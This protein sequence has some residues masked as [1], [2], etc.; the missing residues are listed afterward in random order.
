MEDNKS[1]KTRV[2]ETIVKAAK[3]YQNYFIDYD[4]LLCSDA[5]LKNN[6]YIISGDK[7]NF[8][9]LTGV[10]D[11]ND[12]P[13]DFFEKSLDGTLHEDDFEIARNEFDKNTKGS[14]R[15]KIIVIEDAMRIF[16]TTTFVEEDFV[17][18]N[19]KCSFA[20]ENGSSTIGFIPTGVTT[21]PK[22]LLKGKQLDPNKSKELELVLRKKR[23]EKL[24]T[25][26]VIEI[27]K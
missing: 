25:D 22:T 3:E 15:R 8:K 5:F 19:I 23:N 18:N 7:T 21:R 11:D 16:N 4:Y 27:V 26:I 6:Y 13:T 17:K 20:T 14:I 10:I 24:F 1:F 9:H 12:T 2:K